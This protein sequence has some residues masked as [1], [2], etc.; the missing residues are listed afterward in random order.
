MKS[1]AV[2]H[3]WIGAAQRGPRR[4]EGVCI[5]AG[6]CQTQSWKEVFFKVDTARNWLRRL[7]GAGKARSKT[8][9]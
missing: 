3:A 6:F 5:R 4:S 2:E 9:G 1:T 8:I 7:Q